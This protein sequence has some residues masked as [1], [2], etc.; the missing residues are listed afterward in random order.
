[1]L[2]HPYPGPRSGLI[3]VLCFAFLVSGCASTQHNPVRAFWLPPSQEAWSQAA[4]NG[5][6]LQKPDG[7]KR[8]VSGPVMR[9]VVAAKER[10]EQAIHA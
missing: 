10:L 6:S 9:N 3:I 7:S 1:M 5:I 8:F 2:V 4:V